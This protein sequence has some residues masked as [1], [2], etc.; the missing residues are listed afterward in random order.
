ML[1]AGRLAQ[2]ALEHKQMLNITKVDIG[3]TKTDIQPQ[4][5]RKNVTAVRLM[6]KKMLRR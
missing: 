3:S 5:Q 1:Y 2:V 6:L 4:K